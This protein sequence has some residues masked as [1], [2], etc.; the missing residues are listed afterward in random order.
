MPTL[1]S[2]SG[3][4]R[5]HNKSPASVSHWIAR[6]QL[7]A[8]ALRSDGKIDVELANRQLG[9]TVD[10]V[11]SAAS[12][13][14]IDRLSVGRLPRRREPHGAV[15]DEAARQ[16]LRAKA[17]IAAAQAARA[18][19]EL[20]L[21]KGRYT[22]TEDVDQAWRKSLT[23][24]V[25][26]LEQAIRDLADELRLDAQGRVVLRKWWRQVREEAA[27]R[28]RAKADDSPKYV[29]DPEEPDWWHRV[30]REQS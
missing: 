26:L 3:F 25:H 21:E 24:L 16:L 18:W 23:E 11:R 27:A 6:Q 5:L 28:S 17:Q 15:Y 14:R 20:Q 12:T 22:L 13:N 8:P 4:A 7:T 9:L 1:L 30:A 29:A 19:R 2:K 10:R